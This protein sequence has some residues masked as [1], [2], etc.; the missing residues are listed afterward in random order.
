M[1]SYSHSLRPKYAT[2]YPVPNIAIMVTNPAV[3]RTAMP[4]NA[5]P[6][7]HP[8]ANCAPIPT[9]HRRSRQK[10]SEHCGSRAL[11]LLPFEEME[12]G[13]GWSHAA[14]FDVDASGVLPPDDSVVHYAGMSLT[15]MPTATRPWRPMEWAKHRPIFAAKSGVRVRLTKPRIPEWPVRT[16]GGSRGSST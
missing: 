15:S 10:S 8:R 7:M 11:Q 12:D 2:A 16:A 14:I 6:L 3:E 9:M 4:L 1:S 13:R 5:A